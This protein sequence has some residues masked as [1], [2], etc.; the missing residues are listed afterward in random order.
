MLFQS[1]RL[2]ALMKH[3]Y[4]F[5]RLFHRHT[6]DRQVGHSAQL[7]SFPPTRSP[8]PLWLH[9]LRLCQPNRS[10]CPTRFQF[11]IQLF[12]AL[13]F[14]ERFQAS[15]QPERNFLLNHL[16]RTVSVLKPNRRR[17]FRSVGRDQKGSL[18][19]AQNVLLSNRF[20]LNLAQG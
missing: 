6:L 3:R 4:L 9:R 19:H 15:Y 2:L 10:I 16:L 12:P 8:F 5:L 18:Q 13:T 17:Q 1:H 14:Q 11:M 7:I 20:R